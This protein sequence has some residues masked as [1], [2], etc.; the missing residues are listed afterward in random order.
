MLHSK[1]VGSA[2]PLAVTDIVNAALEPG[3]VLPELRDSATCC[4]SAGLTPAPTKVEAVKHINLI[5]RRYS[6]PTLS[7]TYLSSSSSFPDTWEMHVHRIS[8]MLLSRY[9]FALVPPCVR[10]MK[11]HRDHH[12]HVHASATKCS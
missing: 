10:Q 8:G 1:L 5:H 11:K 6:G 3:V 7:M 2:P 9:L 4:A 12:P